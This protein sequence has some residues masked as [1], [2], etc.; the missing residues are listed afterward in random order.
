MK[1]MNIIMNITITN[2]IIMTTT[3]IVMITNITTITMMTIAN[4]MSTVTTTIMNIPTGDAA[5][6]VAMNTDIHTTTNT[7]KAKKNTSLQ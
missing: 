6:V 2:I 5:A 7:A 1:N 3:A 4:A